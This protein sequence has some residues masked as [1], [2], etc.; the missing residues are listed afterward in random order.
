MVK[1][2]HDLE[3]EMLLAIE[4][5]KTN[6]H[7]AG[8]SFAHLNFDFFDAPRAQTTKHARFGLSAAISR[9]LSDDCFIGW[10]GQ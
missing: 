6:H 9:F 2:L 5:K 10:S 8:R 3:K 1:T 4:V 7:F